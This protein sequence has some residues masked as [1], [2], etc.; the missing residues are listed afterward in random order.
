MENIFVVVQLHAIKV[1]DLSQAAKYHALWYPSHH[2]AII[3]IFSWYI[4]SKPQKNM[5]GILYFFLQFLHWLSA[6]T[7]RFL[8]VFGYIMAGNPVL[9]KLTEFT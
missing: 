9:D 4:P 1:Q 6:G 2:N 5:H 8:V 7:I 3:T